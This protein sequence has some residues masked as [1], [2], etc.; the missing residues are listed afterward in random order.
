VDVNEAARLD[1][2]IEDLKVSSPRA[3]TGSGSGKRGHDTGRFE[4]ALDE[5][6]KVSPFHYAPEPSSLRG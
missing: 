1:Q 4:C 6:F 2:L 5:L 3:D